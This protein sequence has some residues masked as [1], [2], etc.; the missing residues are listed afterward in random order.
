[1]THVMPSLATDARKRTASSSVTGF[2]AHCRWLRVKICMTSAPIDFAAGAPFSSP[3]ATEPWAPS[4]MSR[5]FDGA[6][7]GRSEV[8]VRRQRMARLEI[9]GRREERRRDQRER[10]PA[11]PAELLPLAVGDV[12]EPKPRVEHPE[13]DP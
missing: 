5:S 3:R 7:S 2:A 6:A 13:A 4:F 9:G 10:D 1:M 11:D 12:L 8:D